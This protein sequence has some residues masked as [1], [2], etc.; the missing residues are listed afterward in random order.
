M[1]GV[2]STRYT[3]NGTDPTPTSAA[4]TAP[5]AVASTTDLRFRSYDVAGNAEAVQ[6]INVQIDTTLPTSSASC[7]GTCPTTTWSRTAVNV[8]LT[9]ADTGSGVAAI[10]YTTDGSTPDATTGTVYAGPFAVTTQV[11]VRYRAIDVAGN[12]GAVNSLALQ[13]DTIAPT[14][15]ATCNGATCA[16]GWYASG[17][18]LVFTGSDAGSGVASVRYTTN[19][20]DPTATSTAYTGPISVTSTRSYR[21]RAFDVAG[22]AGAVTRLDL[23]IDGTLPVTSATC[24]GGTCPTAWVRTA[25]SVAL[26]ATDTGSGVARIVYTTNG[27]TASKTNGTT[28]TGP[29]SVTTQTTISYIAVDVAGNASAA[30]SIALRVDITVP[31][32]TI[33][34][35]VDGAAVNRLLA[36]VIG[37]A[38]DNVTPNVTWYLDGVAQSSSTTS[39]FDFAWITAVALRGPHTI[40]V[41]ATDSAGNVGQS[42]T[43]NVTV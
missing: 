33:T 41:R 6:S 9:G 18:S 8:T 20:T 16:S 21:F 11:T 26:A 7:G 27:T 25:Q 14:V 38:V 23:S 15:A 5:I 3:T 31:V 39:S 43:I 13:V 32:V 34:A 12:L 29:I 19:G 28:Y 36:R 22:N 1:S 2:A 42:A 30:K 17:M 37:T 24:N 10:R 40:F 35:P 4:Y